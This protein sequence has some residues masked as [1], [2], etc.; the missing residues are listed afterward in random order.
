VAAGADPAADVTISPA[1]AGIAL[2]ML[3]PGTVAE[4][5]RQLRTLFG[6][7]DPAAF[8]AS[9]NG[10]EQA[11]AGRVPDDVGGVGDG[12]PGEIT[13]RIANAAFLQPGYPFT[14]DYLAAV[15]RDYGAAL[16]ELD[17]A[18]DPDAA[19]EVINAFV[20]DATEDRITDPLAPGSISADTVLAL[21]NTLF[22]TASWFT[23]FERSQTT[24]SAFTTL[25]GST[26]D[27]D[28]MRGFGNA[29]R[30]GDGWVGATKRHVGSIASQFVLPDPD[31]FDDVAARL[32]DA[33]DELTSQPAPGGEFGMPRFGTRVDTPLDGPLEAMGLT[34]PF[35][36]GNLLGIADDPRLRVSSVVHSTFV[37]YDEDG[38]EAAAATIVLATATGAPVEQPVPVILDRPFFYRIVDEAT[39]A[40]L[41]LG[42]VMNPS[43]A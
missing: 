19:V 30:A 9:M 25:D 1:S 13:L 41:F 21:V 42:R 26:T 15:G 12:D 5:Q 27:V 2:A 32:A 29:S 28:M 37:A 40:T 43:A 24:P 18:A 33:F 20:A 7:D 3:E 39:G 34:A 38:V 8:H 14:P 11:L 23:P 4:A 35:E 10:L 31:R 36:E 17:F 22:L 6:I 16:N